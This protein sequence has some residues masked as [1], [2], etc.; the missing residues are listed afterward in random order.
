M[1]N[2][3]FPQSA[4]NAYRGSKIALVFFALVVL[5]KLVI[6]LNSIFNGHDVASSA[7]GIPV[8]TF[9][10]AGAQAVVSLFASLGLRDVVICLLCVLALIRYRTLVPFLFVLLL[11]EQ[12]SRK[13]INH[14]LPVARTGAQPG[15]VVTLVL[16]A[17]MVVGLALS[18]WRRD[19]PGRA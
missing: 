9:T 14:F 1:L 17:M 5:L 19:D 13:A 3:L 2:P 8:D 18:L 12:L 6:G 10:P 15:S 16:L 4:D 11:L 7:D